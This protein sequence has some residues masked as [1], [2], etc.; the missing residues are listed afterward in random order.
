MDK[1]T[2]LLTLN[3]S[4]ID[5]LIVSKIWKTTDEKTPRDENKE[6]LKSLRYNINVFLPYTRSLKRLDD[7]AHA[8]HK[9]DKERALEVANYIWNELIPLLTKT[10]KNNSR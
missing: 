3:Q 2:K 7:E 4:T 1:G 6:Y 8:Q 10:M 9:N 5:D